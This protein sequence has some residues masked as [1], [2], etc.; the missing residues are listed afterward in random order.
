MRLNFPTIWRKCHGW[1]IRRDTPTIPPEPLRASSL[2]TSHLHSCPLDLRTRKQRSSMW[3]GTLKMLR[4]LIFTSAM[5]GQTWRPPRALKS[6]CSSSSLDTKTDRLCVLLDFAVA[7][8]SWF[9]HIR[10]WHTHKDEYNILFLTYEDMIMDL[11]SAVEKISRFLGRDLD[12]AAISRVVEKATFKNMKE[13]PKANY[14]FLPTETLQGKFMRKGQNSEINLYG[15]TES[16]IWTAA[17]LLVC[18]C[19][20]AFVLSSIRELLNIFILMM[21]HFTH[22]PV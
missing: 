2:R 19:T 21:F 16:C 8:S 17:R 4:C 7:G 15:H 9:D 1:S 14:E 13:D 5:H 20:V 18:L 6:F 3:P 10:E 22:T 12:E 11:R